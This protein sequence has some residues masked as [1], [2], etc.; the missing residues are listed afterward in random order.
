M[1]QQEQQFGNLN[2]AITALVT[3]EARISNARSKP[4]EGDTKLQKNAKNFL[5]QYMKAQNVDSIPL[6]DGRFINLD[7]KRADAKPDREHCAMAYMKFH[8]QPGLEQLDLR[9]RAIE[10]T[11]AFYN[12]LDEAGDITSKVKIE[13]SAKKRGWMEAL[14]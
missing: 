11:K 7:T 14:E 10:F 12:G 8:A 5:Y 13:K 4:A 1:A 9:T 3:A 2:D 6:N